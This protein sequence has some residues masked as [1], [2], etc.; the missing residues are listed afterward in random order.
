MKWYR[1]TVFRA[2][3]IVERHDYSDID[4]KR[5]KVLFKKVCDYVDIL[6]WNCRRNV[7]LYRMERHEGDGD[8][9]TQRTI[10]NKYNAE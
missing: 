2:G 9:W 6:Y 7:R 5:A 3:S 10:I 8:N 4:E 1:I